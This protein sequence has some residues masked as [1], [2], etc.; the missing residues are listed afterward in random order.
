MCGRK[1]RP[2]LGGTW[3]TVIC[4]AGSVD[5]RFL[6]I[7]RS[8]RSGRGRACLP[9]VFDLAMSLVPKN[10]KS[11]RTTRVGHARA[12]ISF[13]SRLFYAAAVGRLMRSA[14]HRIILQSPP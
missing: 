3:A 8:N 9:F 4:E 11:P 13:D 14:Q 12:S 7:C 1:A 6:L 5:G 2:K 10:E